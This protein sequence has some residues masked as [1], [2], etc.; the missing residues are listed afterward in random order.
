MIHHAPKF[1]AEAAMKN[2]GNT[3]YMHAHM[4]IWW[5]CLAGKEVHLDTKRSCPKY[6]MWGGW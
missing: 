2:R 5:T 3:Q 4:N 6:S 1:W